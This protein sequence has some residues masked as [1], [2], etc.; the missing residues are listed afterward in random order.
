MEVAS[1]AGRGEMLW[2][3]SPQRVER[4]TMTRYMRWLAGDRGRSF[5]GYDELWRW[6]VGELE[7]FWASIW[8]FFQVEAATPY[9]TV[10]ASREMPGAEWFAGARLNY[11]QHI[12][13]GKDDAAAAI[14][15]ASELREV[16]ELTWAELR[17]GVA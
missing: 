10:L 7:E 5:A 17:D 4:A 9:S 11:A 13:R 2:E 8:D 1:T 15:H 16:A 12:F 3:P 6:S 14:V